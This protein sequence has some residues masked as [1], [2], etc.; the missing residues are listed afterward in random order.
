MA[1]VWAFQNM[2]KAW[3]H[4]SRFGRGIGVS[5]GIAIWSENFD[6][7]AKWYEGL[8]SYQGTGGE[9]ITENEDLMRDNYD[10]FIAAGL[11]F[12]LLPVFEKNPEAWNAVRKMPI[13]NSSKMDKYMQEWHDTVGISDK[14]YV[15]SIAEVMD[16]TVIS[17]ETP[18]VIA[19]SGLDADVNDDGYVDLY[20]VMIVRSGMQNST[21]YDTDIN[22]DGITDKVDLLIVKAKAMEAIAAAAPRKRKID[23]TM[24]GRI[25][26]Q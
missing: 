22:N 3:K 23:F 7:W 16:I 8:Y 14:Q 2:A 21:A 15:K 24:W 17:T 6:N 10:Q 25:K 9:W 19:S 12:K 18:P 13:T 26:N 1:C 20:D 4:G 11:G 5:G